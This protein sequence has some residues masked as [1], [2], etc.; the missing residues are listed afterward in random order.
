[1]AATHV[2]SFSTAALSPEKWCSSWCLLMLPA[3]SASAC[4]LFRTWEWHRSSG[5]VN[6]TTGWLQEIYAARMSSVWIRERRCALAIFIWM[7]Q[8]QE[9]P[10]GCKSPPQPAF[11][12]LSPLGDSA[13]SVKWAATCHR[14]IPNWRFGWRI[15]KAHP[16]SLEGYLLIPFLYWLRVFWSWRFKSAENHLVACKLFWSRINA[17]NSE[18]ILCVHLHRKRRRNLTNYETG[19]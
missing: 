6:V 4:C 14:E 12:L 3:L 9:R 16:T 18:T 13:P 8:Q 5:S 2:Y 19:K 1:M 17:F 15:Q 11:L 10:E 7:K